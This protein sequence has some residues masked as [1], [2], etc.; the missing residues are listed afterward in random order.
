MKRKMGMM[1]V[2]RR[3]REGRSEGGTEEL[4]RDRGEKKGGTD[5]REIA[6]RG[7]NGRGLGEE[8]CNG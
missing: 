8:R 5:E 2:G 7:A 3:E 1:G 6:G 4:E